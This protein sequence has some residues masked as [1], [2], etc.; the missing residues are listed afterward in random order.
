[1]NKEYL[2]KHEKQ[3]VELRSSGIMQF[4]KLIPTVTETMQIKQNIK[5]EA[6]KK[7]HTSWEGGIKSRGSDRYPAGTKKN[8][9]PQQKMTS[10]RSARHPAMIKQAHTP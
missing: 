4:R 6:K 1:M 9:I 3:P 2:L 5:Q 8:H 7:P 10:R